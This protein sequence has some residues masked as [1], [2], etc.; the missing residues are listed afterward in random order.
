MKNAVQRGHILDFVAPSGGVVSG[1]AYLFN[2]LL[3]VAQTTKDVGETFAGST[4]GVFELPKESSA[5]AFA[6]GEPV[7]WDD[8]AKEMNVSATG[9]YEVGTCVEA[10]QIADTTVKVKLKGFTVPAVS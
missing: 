4:E 1:I 2:G 9:R 5:A 8:S 3:A 10:A 6:V 7:Y